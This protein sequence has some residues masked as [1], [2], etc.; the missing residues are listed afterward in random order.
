MTAQLNFDD[1][2][3]S[4]Y[5][6]PKVISGYKKDIIITGSF[7]LSRSSS[8]TNFKYWE[9]IQNFSYE[10]MNLS[11]S[12]KILLWEDYTV[13]QGVEYLYAL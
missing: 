6:Q 7:M 5:L 8:E 13:Q 1:G 4:L 2:S 9:K 12:G 3:I 10:N 11:D